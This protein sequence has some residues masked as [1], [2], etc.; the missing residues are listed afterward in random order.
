M[1]DVSCQGMAVTVT[2]VSGTM[3]HPVTPVREMDCYPSL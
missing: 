3:C 2:Y 1:G